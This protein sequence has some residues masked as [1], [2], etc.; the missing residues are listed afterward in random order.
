MLNLMLRRVWEDAV[1]QEILL[2]SLLLT[3]VQ[4]NKFNSLLI[5]LE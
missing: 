2:T 5:I 4:L 1:R 3:F